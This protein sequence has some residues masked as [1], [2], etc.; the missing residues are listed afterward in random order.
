M[1]ENT[2]KQSSSCERRNVTNTRSDLRTSGTS[3]FAA[4]LPGGA[5]VSEE[6]KPDAGLIET[7]S[8]CGTLLL[9]LVEGEV[10]NAKPAVA[11]ALLD[12]RSLKLDYRTEYRGMLRRLR[13]NSR[14]WWRMRGHRRRWVSGPRL[15][16]ERTRAGCR[17]SLNCCGRR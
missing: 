2:A 4:A 10:D 8:Y 9:E 12:V 14:V 13:T 15:K 6:W 7:R 17:S 5:G 1:R 11:S 16:S 3:G